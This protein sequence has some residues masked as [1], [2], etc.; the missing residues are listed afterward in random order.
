MPKLIGD[1]PLT[2]A[3]RSRRW[4]EKNPARAKEVQQR[5]KE[6]NPDAAAAANRRYYARNSETEKVRSLEWRKANPEKWK[7]I[8]TA[9]IE[10]RRAIKSGVSTFVVLPK[11][12]ERLYSQPCAGCGSMKD[13]TI[14][15]I[16]PLSRGGKHSIGN[17]QTLCKSCNSSKNCKLLVEWQ[18]RKALVAA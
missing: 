18:A 10:K 11:E 4:R 1:K 14:D 5:F 8:Y 7:R 13:Q 16:V 12:I 6:N 9:S 17:L 2:A 15:H 3:E